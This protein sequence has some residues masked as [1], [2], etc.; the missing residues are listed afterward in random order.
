[1]FYLHGYRNLLPALERELEG[2]TVGDELEVSLRPD[3]AYGYRRD[4]AVQRVPI[5]HLLTR[6]RKYQPGMIVKVNTKQGPKDVTV[7]KVGKFNVDVD[8][9][10]PYADKTLK[11]EIAITGIRSATAEELA[12]RHAHGAHGEAHH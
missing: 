9:N 12:H 1:M 10:H 5:K 6:A 2:K 7:V 8:F 4:D 11:F 3:Q